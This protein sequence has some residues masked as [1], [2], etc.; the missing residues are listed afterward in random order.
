MYPGLALAV[1]LERFLEHKDIIFV[2]TA[3]GLEAQVIPEAGYRL[4]TIASAGLPRRLSV[5]GLKALAQ[6]IKG[7]RQAKDLLKSIRPAVVVGMGG[8]VSAPLVFAAQRMNIPTLI[9]EQNAKLGLANRFLSRRARLVATTFAMDAGVGEAAKIVKVGLP[10]RQEIVGITDKNPGYFGLVE[11]RKT[12][13]IFGGSQG[14]ESINSAAVG[15]YELWRENPDIQVLHLTGERGFAAVS[16]RLH[17]LKLESDALVYVAKAYCHKI[18]RAYAIA[19]VAVCR[20]GAS[21]LAELAARGLPAVLIP[22]PFAAGDHQR[23]NAQIFVNAGAAV[24]IEDS[25]L[26]PVLLNEQIMSILNNRGLLGSMNQATLSMANL[27]SADR[28][29]SLAVSLMAH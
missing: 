19:D 2:G 16:E 13:L 10:L 15:L 23:L 14:A 4:L 5:E 18:Q 29:A 25:R 27:D 24:M 22:Y 7:Y 11:D 9:H 28:L 17:D 1:A 21:T 8:Y 12:I 20:A 26:D 6:I 3:K